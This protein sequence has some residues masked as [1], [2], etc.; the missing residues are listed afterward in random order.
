MKF[1]IPSLVGSVIGYITNWLAIKMLF[2]PYE[3]KRILGF[4]VP[5]TPG[6]I[7]KEKE[8]IAR[9]VSE[10]IGNHLLSK[11]TLVNALCSPKI[12]EH[13]ELTIKNKI[14]K[15]SSAEGNLIEILDEELSINIDSMEG[16]KGY[17]YEGILNSLNNDFKDKLVLEIYNSLEKQLYKNPETI[18]GFLKEENIERICDTLDTYME[19]EDFHNIIKDKISSGIKEMSY[20]EKAINEI[21]PDNIVDAAKNIIINNR[22]RITEDIL[23]LLEN[24]EIKIKIKLAISKGVSSNVN[25]LVAMFLNP[26]TL[27]NKFLS[28]AKE[29]LEEDENKK[30][31]CLFINTYMDKLMDIK[32]SKILDSLSLSE[33]E[34]IID[35]IIEIVETNI[36]SKKLVRDGM[37][38]I[39]DKLLSHSSINDILIKI[40][41]GYKEKLHNL[42]R[43]F[44]YK[45]I[46]ED[47]TKIFIKDTVSYFIDSIL[48]KP[49]NILLQGKEDVIVKSTSTFVKSLY[50]NFIQKEAYEVIEVLNIQKIVEDNINAFEVDFAEEII[51]DIANKE[52]KAITWLGALL[53]GLIGI[54]TPLL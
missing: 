31:I 37:Y 3:E 26:D 27:Y 16:V 1:F 47:E 44:I 28:F 7:P 41:P 53:G 2:R 4:K 35:S 5:F 18:E 42:I 17:I 19:S 9:S 40:E 36:Y 8:R 32:V 54:F 52:L 11:D 24:P 13:I 51:L 29:Y 20:N 22:E 21:I 25:P 43:D 48:K 10:A 46:S 23:E 50:D 14:G 30:E 12:Y 49:L 45:K 33:R 38:S 15:L 34:V 6:L 39:K